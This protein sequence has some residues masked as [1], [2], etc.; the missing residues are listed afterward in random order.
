MSIDNNKRLLAIAGLVLT[1]LCWGGNSVAGR[2]S[3]GEI[4]P[5]ALSFWRWTIAFLILFAWAGKDVVAN[6]KLV[7]KHAHKLVPLAILS[8]SSFN[9]LL[10]LA[11][12]STQAINIAL[13]Q[14]SLPLITMILAVPLLRAFPSRPQMLGIV[15]ALPGLLFILS[16]GN[17]ESLSNLSFG[18]GDLIMMLAT[19]CWG[20]YTVLL[21]KFDV[22]FSG[23]QLLTV[24]TG[25]GIV[26]IAP[27]YLWELSVKGGFELNTKSVML[28][29]YIVLFASLTAYVA[30]NFGVSVLGASHAS[31][32]N[33]LIPVFSASFAIPILGEQLQTY[34][35][36]G[37]A[38]IFT[39]L[40]LSNRQRV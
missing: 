21:K 27:F 25:I 35:F 30:Y 24:L 11:A 31:M 18:Q 33:F 10:Y 9:T 40:W 1:A 3:V 13:I 34:H 7:L 39:G 36:V 16:R 38:F 22:P 14:V 8:I 37:A 5:V 12:Q 26:F 32:F 28:L 19:L 17:M 2:M 23:A 4:P 20:L 15:I 29:T 6:H